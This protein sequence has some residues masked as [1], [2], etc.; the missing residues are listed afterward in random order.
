MSQAQLKIL[1]ALLAYGSEERQCLRNMIHFGVWWL[2]RPR[3][4]TLTP[5]QRASYSRTLRRLS[6]AGLIAIEPKVICLTTAGRETIDRLM[7]SDDWAQ[8]TAL[9][10]DKLRNHADTFNAQRLAELERTIAG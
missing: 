10:P 7:E 6:D 5:S 1:F 9:W 8:V 2:D 4:H 3:R